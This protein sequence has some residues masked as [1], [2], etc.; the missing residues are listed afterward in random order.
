VLSA[1]G[2]HLRFVVEENL[3]VWIEDLCEQLSVV[4]IRTPENSTTGAFSQVITQ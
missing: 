1:G 4:G 2:S 3:N